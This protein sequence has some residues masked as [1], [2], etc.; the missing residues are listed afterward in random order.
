LNE[1]YCFKSINSQKVSF[2][3]L[4]TT[5]GK[6][7]REKETHGI[8]RLWR[9]WRVRLTNEM[10]AKR[11]SGSEGVKRRK[12]EKHNPPFHLSSRSHL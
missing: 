2:F 5:E 10:R 11:Q 3:Y 1:K 6:R 12:K 9:D 7:R 8:E 4:G